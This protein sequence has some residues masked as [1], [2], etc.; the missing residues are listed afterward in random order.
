MP[1][2]T[3]ATR[4]ARISAERDRQPPP[5]GVG[6]HGVMVTVA[7]VVLMRPVHGGV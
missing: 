3:S 6:G 7:V 2:A 1:A 4:N 5:V